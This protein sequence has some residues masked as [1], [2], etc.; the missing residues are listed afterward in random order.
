MLGHTPRTK[1]AAQIL[2]ELDKMVQLGWNRN[3]FF[4]DDNFIG[5]R[6]QIKEEILPALI[7]WRK[8]KKIG[9]FITEASIN[10]ADDP[11]L[12]QLMT[13]AG[14]NSVFVG[15]ETPDEASLKECNKGQN[16]R[17][18]LV[19]SVQTLQRFGLQVM[20]GFIVGFDADTPNIFKRQIEFIQN[21]GIVTA[22]VGMLQAPHGT[23]LYAR[24]ETEGRI[25][26][27]MTGDNADGSTNIIPKMGAELL[28]N[29]YKALMD[30]IYSPAFFYERVKTFLRVYNPPKISSVIHREE[31]GAFFSSIWKLGIVGSERQQYWQLFSGRW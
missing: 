1:S 18:N 6:R 16:L 7:E 28:K 5:N 30:D 9:N 12:M 20:G 22:M 19:E 23:K 29:G 10:L 24:M 15:I 26:K 13:A 8:G 2:A 27:E 11:D 4:V 14:F 17:R 21:S 3:I 25:L 31:I